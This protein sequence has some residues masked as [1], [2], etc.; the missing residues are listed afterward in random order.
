MQ[1]AFEQAARESGVSVE[2]YLRQV[3]DEGF[4]KLEDD[5]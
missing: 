1:E 4:H 5:G 3:I 2:D